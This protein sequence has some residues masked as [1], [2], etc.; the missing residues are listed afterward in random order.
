MLEIKP[1][2]SVVI[3]AY[4][5]ATRIE[6]TLSNLIFPD[7]L[8]FNRTCEV[9]I[10]MDGC[11]DNTPEVVKEII[12][13]NQNATALVFPQR[14]GKGGAIM[15]ALKY[16]RGDVI[17]FID[18]DGSISPSELRRLI[19]LTDRYD[20]VIGSRYQKKSKLERKR[21][22]KRTVMSRAFNIISKIMF[23]RL[24]GISDTQCG[25]K[26]FSKHL[27]D[28][29]QSDILITDFA[30]DVNLIY[31][32]L[33]FGF[34]AKEVGIKWIEK[35]GSKLS[36]VFT[37]HAFIMFFSL[38]RL[39]LYYSRFRKVLYSRVFDFLSRTFYSWSR[40]RT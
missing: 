10:V 12:N 1:Q 17:A 13:H 31:S 8:L 24:R 30:F 34:K 29:I 16:T 26:V 28:T 39:R 20:L 9:L 32:S 27:I 38:I 4:N 11:T 5:E 36:G 3:P 25:V 22:I 15:Q 18:A 37:K 7:N 33:N 23:W 19:E 14:L 35:D 6:T 21:S 40:S 2:L